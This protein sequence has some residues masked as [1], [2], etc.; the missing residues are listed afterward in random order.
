[1][2]QE[3]CESQKEKLLSLR[4]D[5][6]AALVGRDE[7]LETLKET[8][9]TGDDADIAS[10]TIDRTLLNSLGEAANRRLKMIDNALN[11]IKQQTYGLCLVCGKEIP[12]ARLEALP[13]AALCVP[14]QTLEEKRNR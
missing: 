14:C 11:R 5:I 3:F 12:Q 4:K 9:D 6:L 1:M 8:S 7:Q 10:D 13:Y 2:N